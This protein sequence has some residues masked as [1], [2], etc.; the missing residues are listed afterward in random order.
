MDAQ[1][2][3]ALI[4]FGLGRRG[5][6]PLPG[7]PVAWLKGQIT[8]P[9]PTRFPGALSTA[10]C[11]S[12]WR[13]D[14]QDPPPR[15][16][17]SR[18]QKILAGEKIQQMNDALVTSAPFRERLVWFWTNHF[19]VSLNRLECL[20]VAGA[21]IREAIRPHVAGRFSDMVLA[22]M[23]HPAMLMYLDNWT[24]IGPGSQAGLA[25]GRGL[26]ENLARECMELH[27]LSPASGYTQADVTS[28]AQ[29]ITGWTIDFTRSDP[30]FAFNPAAHQP[31]AKAV[32]GRTFP[33]GEQGGVEA[34]AFFA[35]HP[36]CHEFLA[37]K[38][39]RHFVADM[40]P[41]EAV[42][43]IAGVLR[44]THGDLGAASQAL[45]DLP[46]AWAK[47]TKLRSPMDYTAAC[48]RAV[49]ATPA[50]T[51]LAAETMAGLGQPLW[52]PPLPNGWPDRAQD[53]AGPEALLRRGEFANKIAG[54]Y[55]D[56]DP[57]AVAD[58]CLGPYLRAE[59]LGAIRFAGSRRAAMTILMASPE[60]MRR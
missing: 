31:G 10:A 8:Q 12:A 42:A 30:G 45:V 52:T 56:A 28:F 34:L 1:Q 17:P 9:D 4:R 37:T 2:A 5:N 19:A 38:L 23:R 53:W 39:V 57:A 54:R 22:V 25:T 26:N 29:A 40:P 48:A 51:T 55:P 35:G 41:P 11:L 13:E 20:P 6:E 49:E 18:V 36:A 7:D 60:F 59:T 44:D 46:S 21:Y 15:G 47:L 16:T 50:T 14:T 58:A 33:E 32:F 43:A 24:S 27:T 3:Q